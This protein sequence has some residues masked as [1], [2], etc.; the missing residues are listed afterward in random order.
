M[1]LL[2]SV[3][4]YFK[5]TLPPEEA[6]VTNHLLDF[7][8]FEDCPC[9]DIQQNEVALKVLLLRFQVYNFNALVTCGARCRLCFC[10]GLRLLFV[11]LPWFLIVA[12]KFQTA[13]LTLTILIAIMLAL[14]T[15]NLLF[16]HVE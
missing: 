16:H 15:E 1:N 2:N 7:E 4:L 9:Q 8:P 6:V 13:L 10:V 5:A 3:P 12:L 11:S 14:L